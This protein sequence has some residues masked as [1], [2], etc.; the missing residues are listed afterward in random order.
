MSALPATYQQESAT[1]SRT[2]PM[3]YWWRV[4]PNCVISVWLKVLTYLPTL[5]IT[6]SSA[7]PFLLESSSMFLILPSLYARFRFQ[8]DTRYSGEV[9][10]GQKAGFGARN[11]HRIAYLVL[12]LWSNPS[13]LGPLQ[14]LIKCRS[15]NLPLH[16]CS[17]DHAQEGDRNPG[18]G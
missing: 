8:R 15:T 18:E 5:I 13:N 9:I 16:R 11:V 12:R 4:S 10:T 14:Q 6:F 7:F 3:T 2:R 1:W 17:N